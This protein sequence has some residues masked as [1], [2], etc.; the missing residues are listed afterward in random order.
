MTQNFERSQ[1]KQ[2]GIFDDN[3]QGIEWPVIDDLTRF[4]TS[5]DI[6]DLRNLLNPA[7][8]LNMKSMFEDDD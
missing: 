4:S 7:N 6:T 3:F 2:P 8:P 5:L 1:N